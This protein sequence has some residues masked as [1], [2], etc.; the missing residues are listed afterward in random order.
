MLITVFSKGGNIKRYSDWTNPLNVIEFNFPMVTPACVKKG[1]STNITA[2][3]D[4]EIVITLGYQSRNYL[5]QNNLLLNREC[6]N[7]SKTNML[8]DQ[9]QTKTCHIGSYPFNKTFFA[10]LSV[11]RVDIMLEYSSVG[12]LE[13]ALV[14]ASIAA[15]FQYSLQRD[16]VR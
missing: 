15:Y 1:M 10:P 13:G 4:V 5:D 14:R 11:K 2:R 6:L 8:Y 12:K 16:S 9:M 3:L 7:K